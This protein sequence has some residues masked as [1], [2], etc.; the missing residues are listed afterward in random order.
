M[1]TLK[2]NWAKLTGALALA[3]LT[4][5]AVYACVSAWGQTAPVL[6][7]AM[8]GTNQVSVI[9]SNGVPNGVYQ[10]YYREFLTTNYPWIYITNGAVNQTNFSVNTG[11]TVSG[12]FQA[13]YNTNFVI[14]TITVIIQTPTNGALIY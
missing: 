1:R 11:D 3:G 14:P 13:A 5:C 2:K 10:L 6:N 4:I 12:Y 7:I 8:T 9:I